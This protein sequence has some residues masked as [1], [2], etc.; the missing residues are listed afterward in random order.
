MCGDSRRIAIALTG[1]VVL[2]DPVPACHALLV[3][4]CR[5]AT[6]EMTVGFI[7]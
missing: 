4:A 3:V 1:I 7:I 2:P 6:G 5:L